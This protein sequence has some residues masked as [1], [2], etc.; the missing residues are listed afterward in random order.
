LGEYDFTTSAA[1][2]VSTVGTN[3]YAIIHAMQLIEK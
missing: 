3:G 1:V 2:E